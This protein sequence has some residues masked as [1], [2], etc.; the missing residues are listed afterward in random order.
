MPI[1]LLIL[2]L[3]TLLINENY[4][5]S[6]Y[7]FYDVVMIDG[8]ASRRDSDTHLITLK[9]HKDKSFELK[10]Q[11][12]W[13]EERLISSYGTWDVDSSNF[14]VL[15]IKKRVT[16]GPYVGNKELIFEDLVENYQ[17]AEIERFELQYREYQQYIIYNSDTLLC[18][19]ERIQY[20]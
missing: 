3:S 19:G 20:E 7:K 2:L 15:S 9:L 1:K 17:E 8:R 12:G 5:C 14:L 11:L 13:F 16:K 10:N 4:V 18:S 6:E